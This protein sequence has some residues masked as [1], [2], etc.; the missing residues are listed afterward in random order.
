MFSQEKLDLV[1]TYLIIIQDV[2]S[3]KSVKKIFPVFGQFF[4][5][6]FFHKK[7]PQKMSSYPQKKWISDFSE[8]TCVFDKKNL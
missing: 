1:V 2:G 7:N 3:D 4:F 6:S 8:I 5:Y